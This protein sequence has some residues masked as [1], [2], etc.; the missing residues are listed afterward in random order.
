[1]ISISKSF[2]TLRGT[3]GRSVLILTL[4]TFND[5]SYS[6]QNYGSFIPIMIFNTTIQIYEKNRKRPM[7]LIIR[8]TIIRIIKSGMLP[9]TQEGCCHYNK[10]Y[11]H[12]KNHFVLKWQNNG[13]ERAANQ[14][15]SAI[16]KM[17]TSRTAAHI[18]KANI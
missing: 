8:I 3:G 7:S 6:V 13:L 5:N 9:H 16:K 12:R 17:T 11:I 10:E 1:M 14:T 2:K 15:T 18:C 4:K